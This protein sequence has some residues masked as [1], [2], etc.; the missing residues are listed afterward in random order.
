MRPA[1]RET[2]ESC[3]GF[4]RLRVVYLPPISDMVGTG[5]ED[6]ILPAGSTLADLICQLERRHGEIVTGLFYIKGKWDP[7]VGILIK[8]RLERDPQRVLPGEAEIALLP[9]LAGG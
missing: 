1:G 6:I 7:Q 2:E 8:G 5:G 9:T 4:S 3:P